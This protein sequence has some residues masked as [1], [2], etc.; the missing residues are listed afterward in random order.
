L[1]ERTWISGDFDGDNDVDFGDL[2]VIAQNYSSGSVGDASAL[3]AS[4]AADWNLARSLVPEPT[5]LALMSLVGLSLKR[6]R[7]VT[8]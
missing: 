5:A 1:T 2:L 3:S 6:S 8:A 4:F 7:K